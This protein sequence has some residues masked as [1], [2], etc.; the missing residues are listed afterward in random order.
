MDRT[1]LY[2]CENIYSISWCTMMFAH[3][4]I[5]LSLFQTA[6]VVSRNFHQSCQFDKILLLWVGTRIRISQDDY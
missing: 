6:T 4:E 1:A 5:H 2:L 3:L